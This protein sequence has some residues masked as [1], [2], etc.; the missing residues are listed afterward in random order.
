VTEISE[1]ARVKVLLA[2]FANQDAAGKVNLLGA[3]WL[4][5]AIQPTGMTPPQTLVVLVDVPSRFHGEDFAVSVT[6]L[7]EAGQPVNVP[8]PTGEMQRLRVQQLLRAERPVIPGA[9]VPPKVSGRVQVILSFNAGIPLAPGRQYRWR[10]E[11]DG[12]TNPQW[13]ANFYVV[14]LPPE[15]VIG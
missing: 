8:G 5:T 2:D 15:P 14:G 10:V 9:N 11:I 4:V 7:D 13:E 3:N 1:N 6:L 12:N